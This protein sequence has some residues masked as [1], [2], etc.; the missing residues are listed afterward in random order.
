M[1][2]AKAAVRNEL[3]AA[4][5]VI[6]VRGARVHNLQ[7]LDVDVPLDRLVVFTG[8]SGSGKSSLAFDTIHAEG[9]RR[10]IESLSVAARPF[11]DRI[12]RPDVD[13]VEGLPPTVALDQR[14]GPPSRRST[15]GTIT[16]IHDFLRIL[17][18]RTGLPH[19]SKCRRAIRRQSP[20]EIVDTV[21]A[22]PEGRKLMVLAPLVRGRK[23]EHLAA[24]DAIRRDGLL[25][26]RVDGEIIEVRDT[27]KLAKT[28]SHDIEA[29]VDRLVVREG[30]RPRL[31]ESVDRALKLGDGTITLTIAG[32]DNAGWADRVLSTRYGCPDC[33]VGLAELEPR[34]FSFNSPYGACPKCDGLGVLG[35][36]GPDA[37][38]VCPD[39]SGARLRP[40]ARAV[41][42]D[43]R[44]IHELTAMSIT[45]LIPWLD[46]LAF[47]PPLDQ[48]GPVLLD[49]VRPRVRSLD[50]VGLGY[51]TLD[52][53]ADT[54]SGGELQR[55]R[56]AGQIGPGLVGVAYVLDEP[57][58][59]LHPRD[60]ERLLDCLRE[61]RARGNSVLVV[62]HDEA[63]IRAADWVIDLGPG[64]GPDGGR[65]VASGTPADLDRGPGPHTGAP[66]ETP[67]TPLKTAGPQS[68][69]TIVGARAHNLKGDAA[70]FPIGGLT[71]VTGVSGS[72][73]SSLVLDVLGRAGDR[74]PVPF[75]RIEG[76]E[77]FARVVL[78]DQTPIGRTPRST[79]ATAVG[80]F[81]E[82]RRV[83]AQVREAKVRGF[84]ASRF[85]F[86]APSGRCE[87][88]RGHG[89]RRIGLHFLPDLFVRCD[90]CEGRRFNR[91][92]LEVRYKGKSIADV[93]A[94]RVDAALRLFDAVPKVRRGL[95][96]LHEAGLGYVT[97]GQSSTTLSGGEAQRVKLA[98]ELG[99]QSSERTLFLLDEPTTGLH[100]TD[101]RRLLG[102]FR[103][104]I[105]QG[106]T[107]VVI[108][109]NLD[110]IRAADWVIDLGPEGGDE[111]GHVV[112]MG[113]PATVSACPA[114]ITGRYL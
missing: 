29:V 27:P 12:E 20:E 84:K 102:V 47:S 24:F 110:V 6:R 95:N 92:T 15:V 2:R 96:A 22:L 55:V 58:V 60:T 68:W 113:T 94:L 4:G 111:G 80:V 56:L 13:L 18:A 3:A 109:H 67:E 63:V 77:A 59:G 34:T 75:E 52:R 89:V 103:G 73:K 86:N 104:L 35:P 49:E 71:C 64:A 19:C 38:A 37:L 14:P 79:P 88:C 23:G 50:R 65:L 91:A 72:G 83:F 9:R 61:L 101:V 7:G 90:A 112:V 39:C 106:H 81:D 107:L 16:E 93:L 42:L 108:E 30:I 36:E 51:L 66:A 46:A 74:G 70:R 105:E 26:A 62:E 98:A 32:D 41:T 1:S 48:V 17:F 40:E 97:L 45:E 33:G 21:L 44:A 82:V 85:S 54:L 25:R 69:I 31:A 28:K 78:V 53:G 8:V 87:V 99:R 100:R 43:G 11:L 10:Y 5:D 76:I 114:G 57:T